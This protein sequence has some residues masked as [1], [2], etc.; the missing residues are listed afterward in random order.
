MNLKLENARKKLVYWQIYCHNCGNV[1]SPGDRG[2]Q[3][4]FP[5]EVHQLPDAE[6]QVR[7][8]V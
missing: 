8:V 2:G 1:W 6:L 3:E 7:S 4:A 5:W